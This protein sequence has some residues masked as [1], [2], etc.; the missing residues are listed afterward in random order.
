MRPA[1]EPIAAENPTRRFS[2]GARRKRMHCR[3]SAVTAL[4]CLCAAGCSRQADQEEAARAIPVEVVVTAREDLNDV[5]VLTGIL[6]AYRAVDLVSEVS[7][8]IEALH[9][10]VGAQVGS[11]ALLATIDQD[12]PRE[13]LRQAEAAC[14]AAR[15]RHR[16]A[17]Q[18]YQRDSTLFA[19]RDIAEAAFELS[20]MNWVAARAELKSTEAAEALAARRLRDTEIRAPFAGYLARRQAELGQFVSVATPLFR[21]VDIDSL[22]LVLGVSQQSVSR[23]GRG[24]PVTIE[25]DAL[26]GRI[27]RGHVR[28]VSPEAD[29][30]TRTFSVEVIL[31]NPAGHPLKDG[32]IVR[33]TLVLEHLSGVLAAARE[34]VLRQGDELFVYVIVDDIAERRA[35]RTGRMIGGRHVISEGL[36]PGERLVCV[37]QENLREGSRVEIEA[38]H[39]TTDV[40]TGGAS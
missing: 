5:V 32:M 4:A 17:H 40:V 26:P 23:V 7:G 36:R 3:L 31:A 38:E 27:F 16:V 37:G 35:V 19:G 14:M 33:G 2:A 9:E 20:R 30:V 28:S 39:T 6:D 29:E 1:G 8:T 10:D 25:A 22:R 21:L 15:A 24:M 18:D 13:S 11:R 12:I 34:V